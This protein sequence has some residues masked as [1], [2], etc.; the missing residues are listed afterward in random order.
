M[1]VVVVHGRMPLFYAGLLLVLSPLSVRAE[2]AECHKV[3]YGGAG[4]A[5]GGI[6]YTEW[7]STLH[8]PRLVCQVG[9]CGF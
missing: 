9:A 3:V 5:C 2:G 8:V 4:G 6:Y 7:M 1:S